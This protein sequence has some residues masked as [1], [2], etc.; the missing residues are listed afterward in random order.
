MKK[1]HQS[2]IKYLA[3]ILKAWDKT[4]WQT[5]KLVKPGDIIEV[6]SSVN[7]YTMAQIDEITEMQITARRLTDNAKVTFEMTGDN[8]D[9]VVQYWSSVL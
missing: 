1:S 8:A 4:Q 3:S 7:V 5:T 9:V 6:K 2:Q